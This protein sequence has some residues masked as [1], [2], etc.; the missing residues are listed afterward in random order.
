MS[1]QVGLP[2]L[3]EGGL[4][5]DGNRLPAHEAIPRDDHG[6]LNGIE[7]PKMLPCH[8]KDDG[9]ES[10]SGFTGERWVKVLT[11]AACAVSCGEA[12]PI[13]GSQ[14]VLVS[15]TYEVGVSFSIMLTA[16]R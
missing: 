4:V 3:L 7:I 1:R 14:W 9:G 11:T 5:F 8:A 15:G 10:A 6:A 2:A 16:S 12:C 13:F